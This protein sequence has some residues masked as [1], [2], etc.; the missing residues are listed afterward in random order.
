MVAKSRGFGSMLQCRW[1]SQSVQDGRISAKLFQ[2]EGERTP[3]HFLQTPAGRTMGVK[4]LLSRLW[5]IKTPKSL[6][7]LREVT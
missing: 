7:F 5:C 2:K 4:G 1:L 6:L 3:C